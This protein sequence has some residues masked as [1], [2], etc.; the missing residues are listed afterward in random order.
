MTPYVLAD[1]S[2]WIEKIKGGRRVRQLDDL[3]ENNLVVMH[4]WVIGEIAMGS[5]NRRR[6]I[7]ADLG[8]LMRV[9]RVN[10]SEVLEMIE[11]RTLWGRGIGWVDVQLA[12]SA[13]VSGVRLWTLDRSLEN[14]A[15]SLG[16]AYDKG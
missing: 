6:D 10:E 12:A 15:R 3:L 14:V 2:I 9:P 7:L 1:S 11:A 16:I 13:L 8:T 4:S 5:M